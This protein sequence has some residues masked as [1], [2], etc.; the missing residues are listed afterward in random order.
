M[1]I[2][3][4]ILS[5]TLAT[6][7]I[8]PIT[9]QDVC[10]LK[11]N[12]SGFDDNTP[13]Y[14]LRRTGEFTNDTV[15]QSTINGGKFS[16]K[17]SAKMYGEQYNLRFGKA[18][19]L[20]SFFAEKGTVNFEGNAQSMMNAKVWGTPDNEIW[21]AFMQRSMQ[22]SQQQNHR[23]RE[24]SGMQLA[25]SVKRKMMG[26]AFKQMQDGI[27]AYRDSLSRACPN[28]V[29]ALYLYYQIL[30]MLKA[31]QINDVLG[32]FSTQLADNR[33]YREMKAQAELLGT[34]S[35]GVKAPDFEVFTPEGGKKK[36][37][38]F[39][40]KHV[41]LDFWASW[42]A[43]CRKETMYIKQL[44]QKYHDKGLEIFSVSLDDK[45]QPWLKAI[46]DDGMPWSHGC[47]LLRG[48]KNT[49][50]AKLYGIDGIPAIWV[51]G[52]D[53]T[54]LADGLREQALVD[55]CTKLFEK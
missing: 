22:L 27:E 5:I 37:S 6:V 2:N 48:G 16:F 39:R 35:A 47:Q 49:P 44:Y 11:G 32:R 7:Y 33:Y 53:G 36:L 23:M 29:A 1:K 50:V 24:I 42:C 26:D 45:K 41:I 21:T 20:T 4:I 19:F 13:V 17:I 3:R 46:K 10:E 52:P 8:L 34:L 43:P 54:I 25:D 14:M 9:A 15:M 40:G 55:F 28:S 12:V 18:R 31:G 51:I 30:P 38:S